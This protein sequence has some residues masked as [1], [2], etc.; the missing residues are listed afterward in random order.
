L[1]SPDESARSRVFSEPFSD[2]TS[3]YLALTASI[4]DWIFSWVARFSSI[5][6]LISP[7]CLAF[8]SSSVSSFSPSPSA[9]ASSFFSS[10]AGGY[11]LASSSPSGVSFFSSSGLADFFLPF[12]CRI[13]TVPRVL[14]FLGLFTGIGSSCLGSSFSSFFYKEASF[15]FQAAISLL[16]ASSRFFKKECISVKHPSLMASRRGAV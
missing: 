9:G 7:I 6:F 10:S 3:F 4:F 11:S 15:F 13:F 8:F 14:P 16:N 5:C 2:S 12:F 1:R